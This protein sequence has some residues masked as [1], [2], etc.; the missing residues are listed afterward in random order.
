MAVS[1]SYKFIFRGNGKSLMYQPLSIGLIGDYNPNNRTHT[2][3]DEALSHAAAALAVRVEPIWLPT[4]SLDHEF[5]RT[6][7]QQ[8]DALWCAPASPYDS[9][10]GALRAIRFAREEGWPFI[11]T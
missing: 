2:A 5:S 7:L 1:L 11:G 10:N 8:F 9:M 6:T 3:T 4:P